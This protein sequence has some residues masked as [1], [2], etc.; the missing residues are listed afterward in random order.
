MRLAAGH[1]YPTPDSLRRQGT[2]I[3]L[4]WRLFPGWKI[5]KVVRENKMPL[6]LLLLL[7]YLAPF[8][9]HMTEAEFTSSYDCLATFNG[10]KLHMHRSQLQYHRR[11]HREPGIH[12]ESNES[13]WRHQ[14]PDLGMTYAKRH[15]LHLTQRT[16]IAVASDR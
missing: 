9:E 15:S 4:V 13:T 6:Q 11:S 8:L 14:E 5:S 3:S 12:L 16:N 1:A 10:K 7:T 2:P